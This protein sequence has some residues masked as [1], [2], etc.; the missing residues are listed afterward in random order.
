MPHIPAKEG[1]LKEPISFDYIRD[2]MARTFSDMPSVAKRNMQLV[3]DAVT[4]KN[5][6]RFGYG[7]DG[8]GGFGTGSGRMSMAM[9]IH[10]QHQT[11]AHLARS[12]RAESG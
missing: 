8:K 9:G 11:V 12:V 5:R 6:V 2:D 10:Q 1:P 3:R 4:A 7:V